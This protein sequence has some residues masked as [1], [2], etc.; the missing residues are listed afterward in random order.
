MAAVAALGWVSAANAQ[1]PTGGNI[2]A[3]SGSI[4]STGNVMTITQATDRMAA[5]W[6]SFSIGQGNTVNFVQPSSSAVAL[7]RVLGADVSTIQGAINANGKVFLL[8][9][10]GV[11]FTPT[12]QVN[13][14]SLVASTLSLGNSDFLAGNYKFEGNSTATIANQGNI[15]TTSGGTI[16]LIAAKI[17]N[18]GNLNAHAGN[19]LLGAGSKV[20][21]DMG[22]PVKLQV[23]NDQLE[24]L[25][26]NGGAI[27]ANGG[28]VLLTSQAAANLASSVINHTGVIEANALS[29]GETGNVV[30]FAHGGTM[31]LGGTIAASK[32]FVETSGK[33]FAIQ[34][35]ASV[36][37]G[38]WLIDPVDIN[39][40][41]T[42]AGTIQTALSSTSEVIV[43]TDGACT[44]VS[45][46][47]GTGSNGDITVSSPI[48]WSANKLTLSASRNINVN[49]TL[50]ASGGGSLAFNYGQAS[51]DGAGS[52][53]SVSNDAKIY[54]GSANDFTW[55][56]GNSGTVNNLIFDNGN[57]RFG[58]GTQPALN[59]DGLLE[60][61]WY[62]DNTSVVS[63]Q[64]RNSWYKL[65][66]SSYPLNME[67]GAGG[68]GTDSWN[69][70]GSLL[71]SQSNLS[72]AISNR[73]FD[74]SGYRSGTGVIVSSVT[75]GFSGGESIK[76]D[77]TYTLNSGASFVKID[78][79]LT[80]VGTGSAGNLRLWVGTQ[81][82]YVATRDSQYKYKGNLTANGFE[83]ISA[84]T[85]QAKALKI[86]EFD[87]GEGAAI[88][89]YSISSGADTSISQCCD[90][91]NASGINPRSS[92]ISRG[93]EDGS[94]A[95]FIRLSDLAVN[96]SGGMT[97]YY[98][99]SPASQIN[100]TV[101]QVS[102]SSG[103]TTSST[104]TT[105]VAL[106][107]AV[108]RAIQQPTDVTRSLG[109]IRP[110]NSL[111]PTGRPPAQVN[112]PQQ[113]SLPVVD[114]SGGLAIVDLGAGQAPTQGNAP[115]P[116]LPQGVTGTDPLGFMRVFV[117]Q[118][119]INTPP[120]ARPYAAAEN[121]RRKDELNR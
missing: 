86:T 104:S 51:T 113:A 100:S 90:F 6:S 73:K 65:T 31:S 43:T 17:I 54:I 11:L 99:A 82:D 108:Q 63:G 117:T 91:T 66:Y 9:P 78:T 36:A 84:Q 37:T 28:T 4:A 16:A 80:N 38:T 55:Q 3:G 13:V 81:D 74:I 85:Q 121:A 33:N 102:Q 109:S 39:I 42:L 107:E 41:A 89:F 23:E 7:N 49:A 64:T 48:T 93:P 120:E 1:L 101:T 79:L 98:A 96:Q 111:A 87:N 60:Q 56:K 27:R 20:T 76:V 67:V 58:N 119:G 114:M 19:V 2:V 112:L 83:M 26:A 75:L 40:D 45:C 103:A 97:W 8:N 105:N 70:N 116:T 44:G 50:D 30:L 12:A 115:A 94:Y 14:G 21:L 72:G 59:N 110:M 10:N 53:Y 35:G 77:N 62:F 71:D 34:S 24:T 61:P 22:G 52:S 46:G 88:L 32:G 118:G 69:R 15:S 18:D 95:L 5:N 25:I 29:T 106:E 47:S 57:L 92:D 68:D